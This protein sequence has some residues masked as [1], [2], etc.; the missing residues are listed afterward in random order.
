MSERFNVLFQAMLGGLNLGIACRALK[1]EKYYKAGLYF[2]LAFLMFASAFW[3]I[4]F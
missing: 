4:V 1:D 2:G 3:R